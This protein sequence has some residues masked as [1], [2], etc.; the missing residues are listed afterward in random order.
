[1]YMKPSSTS[2]VASRYSFAD[3][4][5]SATA[6]ASFRFLTLDLLIASSGENRW[7]PKS[8]WFISQFCGSG[9]SNR[10]NVTSAADAFDEGPISA[11]PNTAAATPACSRAVQQTRP[12]EHIKVLPKSMNLVFALVPR[13]TQVVCAIQHEPAIDQPSGKHRGY[14]P[15]TD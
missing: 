13:L 4:P 15:D 7:E 2:G 9:L 6:K 10:S 12:I 11:A 14:D 1:M 8:R 3:V 5:P